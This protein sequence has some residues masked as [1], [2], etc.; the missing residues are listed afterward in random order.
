M[1]DIS[2]SNHIRSTLESN[3]VVTDNLAIAFSILAII[4]L[5]AILIM[6]IL[7]FT[8]LRNIQHRIEDQY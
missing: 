4:L 5:I 6:A 8:T 7:C 3:A 2:Y 1:T